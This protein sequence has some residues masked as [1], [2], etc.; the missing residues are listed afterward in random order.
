[1]SQDQLRFL[2]WEVSGAYNGVR[3]V[4][5]V[6]EESLIKAVRALPPEEARKVMTWAGQLADL[7]QGR[8]IQWSDAWTDQD[9][10]DA[11]AAS[12]KRF[13]EQERKSS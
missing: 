7:A 4:L 12:L 10:A 11:T 2:P 1:M 9:I 13:E 5:S 3:M 6:E 8:E